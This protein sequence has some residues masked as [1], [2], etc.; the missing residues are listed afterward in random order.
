MC[1]DWFENVDNGK[2][3]GVV[4][5]IF[6]KHEILLK[7]LRFYGIFGA[8][9]HWFQSY[10]TNRYQRTSLNGFLSKK[11][12]DTP[13]NSSRLDSRS[14]LFLIYIND[15]PNC[16]E[17]TVPF[18]YADDTQVFASSHDSTELVDKF[19]SDLVNIMD[20]L[21]GN[22]LQSHAI[23]TKF[24]FVGSAYNLSTSNVTNSIIINTLLNWFVLKSVS[25]LTLLIVWHLILENICKKI[26][27]GIVVI[28]IIKPFVPLRS[29]TMLF[30]PLIQLYFDYCSPLWDTC[31]KVLK[32]KLQVLQNRVE[33]KVF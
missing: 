21:T 32:D 6:V 2:L 5:W 12:K 26:C 11:K 22:K 3:T 17:S 7:K 10:L 27:S 20:W 29:L 13:W 24:M 15:L 4:F 25:V 30:K 18:L 16:L 31:V 14:L 28:K 19:N 9:Y 23:K 1:D 33:L 8:E